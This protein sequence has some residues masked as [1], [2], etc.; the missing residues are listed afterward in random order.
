VIAET[1]LLV[2]SASPGEVAEAVQQRFPVSRSTVSTHITQLE[3]RLVI[4]RTVAGRVTIT[5]RLH[6]EK[7]LQ[8]AR[9]ISASAL[10]EQSAEMKAD[11]ALLSR[12]LNKRDPARR[13]TRAPHA[14]DVTT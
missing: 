4:R 6:T 1:L 11:H 12:R 3:D 13:S 7:I 9:S 10:A 2:D 5:D 14:E 8:S